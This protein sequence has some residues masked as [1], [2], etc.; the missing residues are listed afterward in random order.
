LVSEQFTSWASPRTL[1]GPGTQHAH[2]LVIDFGDHVAQIR[3]LVRDRAGQLRPRSTRCSRM[4]ASRWSRSRR[5]ARALR[6][7]A[8]VERFI[9][10]VRWEFLD[11]LLIW[12][13]T[14]RRRPARLHQHYSAH[15]PHRSLHR[16]PPEGGAQLSDRAPARHRQSTMFSSTRSSRRCR[17]SARSTA[18]GRA[19]TRGRSARMRRSWPEPGGRRDR[20]GRDWPRCP[21]RHVGKLPSLPRAPARVRAGSTSRSG[22][23]RRYSPSSSADRL[24]CSRRASGAPCRNVS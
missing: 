16:R 12:T 18:A 13:T 22:W 15:R 8:I 10:T 17:D 7:N 23:R 24:V 5:A 21:D 9:G 4:W 19:A 20:L 6:A 11:H 2:N 3:F 1:T 14:P